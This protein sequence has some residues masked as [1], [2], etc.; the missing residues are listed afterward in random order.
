MVH[1]AMHGCSVIMVI[2]VPSGLI[3]IRGITMVIKIN[4]RKNLKRVSFF[5]INFLVINVFLCLLF[6][7]ISYFPAILRASTFFCFLGTPK[8]SKSN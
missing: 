5:F 6:L 4:E 2:N 7:F 1:K 8:I 3:S